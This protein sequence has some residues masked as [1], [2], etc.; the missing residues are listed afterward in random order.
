[1]CIPFIHTHDCQDCRELVFLILQ[2]ITV[3]MLVDHSAR[4][5]KL[6]S[7]SKKATSTFLMFDTRY[8]N[9]PAH[10]DNGL[11]S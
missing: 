6:P 8:V 4:K 2:N 5:N 10:G 7:W 9:F 11:L 3:V 1:M